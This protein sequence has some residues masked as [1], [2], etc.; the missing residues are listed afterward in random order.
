[1]LLALVL[2]PPAAAQLTG[3]DPAPNP[4]SAAV[5]M[6]FL[7]GMVPHHRGAIAMAGLATQKATRP[8]LRELAARMIEDQ[9]NEMAQMT[10]FLRDWYGVEPPAG[11]EMPMEAMMGMAPM[12]HNLLPDERARMARLEAL[13]G[14]AFDVEFMSAM[15]D[16]HAMAIAMAAPVLIHGHHEDL[17]TL[18]ERIVI[19]Q[20][21]EIRQ[22]DEWL[23]RWY[24]VRRPLEGPTTTMMAMMTPPH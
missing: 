13:I 23:Q 10:A 5:E 12:L 17:Y 8:E 6:E 24:D 22:M 9:R 18:A 19:S 15:T 4:T 3:R 11:A 16:H 2:A 20:G 7:R 21:E 14:P 1:L